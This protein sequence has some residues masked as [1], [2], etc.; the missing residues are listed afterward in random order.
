MYFVKRYTS[1]A[2]S[3]HC[4]SNFFMCKH[5]TIFKDD[6]CKLISC[7][8]CSS[9]SFSIVFLSWKARIWLNRARVSW[10]VSLKQ[11]LNASAVSH[12]AGPHGEH[13]SLPTSTALLC[14][15][16]LL[17]QQCW[18]SVRLV[19]W[20]YSGVTVTGCTRASALAF[21]SL[22]CRKEKRGSNALAR[23]SFFLSLACH[24]ALVV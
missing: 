18:E 5:P 11:L 22:M 24:V 16:S 23:S 12:A 1:F 14:H 15:S 3:C 6:L 21:S 10:S 20:D 8:L 2:T 9:S 19:R 13:T 17:A 7:M 4:V